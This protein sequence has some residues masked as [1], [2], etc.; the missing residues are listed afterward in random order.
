MKR[1][2]LFGAAIAAIAGLFSTTALGAIGLRG[3]LIFEEKKDHVLVRGNP[4]DVIALMYRYQDNLWSEWRSYER[5]VERYKR[6]EKIARRGGS[7][8]LHTGCRLTREAY[9]K[10]VQAGV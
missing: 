8:R 5:L 6:L 1:R 2:T 3:E 7:I 4:D 9:R 10:T